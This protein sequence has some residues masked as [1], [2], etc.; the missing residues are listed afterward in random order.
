MH[1]HGCKLNQCTVTLTRNC[2]LRCEFC[3]AKKAGY[4]C[5]DTVDYRD[6]KKVID[7]CNAAKV[8]YVVLSGGEPTLYP[9]LLATIKYIKSQCHAMVPTIATNGTML[10][11]IERCRSLV[12]AGVGYFD[13]SLKG[14]DSDEFKRITGVDL[15]GKQ[16]QAIANL[17]SLG[18]DFTC[19]MVLSPTNIG[20]FCQTVSR[21]YDHGGRKF[22]FTFV[23]DNEKARLKDKAYLKVHNP[24]A[25]VE[26]FVSQ[27]GE[28]ERITGGEWWIEYSFPLC[29]YTTEQLELLQGR[30]ASPCQIYEKNA[31]TFDTGLN[32]IPCSMNFE[33]RLGRLGL[34]FSSVEEFE[35]LQKSESYSSVIDDLNKLPSE[36]CSACKLLPKC[37]GGC[38]F[39][40]RNCTF[41]AFK[42]FIEEHGRKFIE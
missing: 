12:V 20:G 7:F 35:T 38:T 3:Y 11:D 42:E 26:T 34:N 32:L 2:N 36:H 29:V 21:A 5:A 14:G 27:I 6:L 25:L 41:N 17:S 9:D 30:L 16:L 10:D 1:M 24:I 18:V 37:R 40:W 39:F 15:Y 28:L 23:I 13:V 31:V 4:K 19:S 8:R 22:S 33:T